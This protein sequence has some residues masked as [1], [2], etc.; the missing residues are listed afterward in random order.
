[1]EGR[2][3]LNEGDPRGLCGDQPVAQTDLLAQC[4]PLRFLGEERVRAGIDR[5]SVDVLAEDD[6]TGPAG[7]FED[8][9]RHVTSLELVGRRE[10]SDAA[11]DN[12]CVNIHSLAGPHPRSP[13]RSRR[14]AR[15]STMLRTT[16][17]LS[18]GRVYPEQNVTD[19]SA[20]IGVAGR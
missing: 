16:L 11:A 8:D 5:E 7:A 6:A 15:P 20:F 14:G 10:P 18:K 2:A 9:A 17:S 3:S 1:M 12:H 4:D 13:T 19:V